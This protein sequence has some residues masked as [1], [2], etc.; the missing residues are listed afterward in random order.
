MCGS[1]TD[2]ERLRERDPQLSPRPPEPKPQKDRPSGESEEKQGATQ[3]GKKN[4]GKTFT[5]CGAS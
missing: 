2:K 3:V 1:H 5:N 4:L